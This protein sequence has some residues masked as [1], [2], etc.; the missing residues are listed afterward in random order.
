MAASSVVADCLDANL[1]RAYSQM[2]NT[3]NHRH[4][5]YIGYISED[6]CG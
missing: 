3:N 4:I 2:L 1:P 6:L 5:L